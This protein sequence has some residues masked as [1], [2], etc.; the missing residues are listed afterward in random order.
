VFYRII[1]IFNDVLTV[2]YYIHEV[3]DYD[4]FLIF[5]LRKRYV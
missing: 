2:F 5:L 1:F 4:F 3:L